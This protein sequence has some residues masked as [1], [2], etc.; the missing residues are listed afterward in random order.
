V[1]PGFEELFKKC[2]VA[3]EDGSYAWTL[4]SETYVSPRGYA[5][6]VYTEDG[7]L[8]AHACADSQ[9]VA[10]FLVPPAKMYVR[11]QLSQEYRDAMAGL[12]IQGFIKMLYQS[13]DYQKLGPKQIDGIDAIGFET[14]DWSNRMPKELEGRIAS[15]LL[16]VGDVTAR[17]W[18]DPE[19]R[20]PI[21]NEVEG[22]IAPCVV[23]LF[24]KSHLR[25]VD[26]AF[27]WGLPIDEAKF[28][29]E[30]PEDYRKITL[31]S[32]AAIGATA[33][34]AALAAI[35]PCW[36]FLARRSRRSLMSAPHYDASGPA[37][38]SAS[39]TIRGTVT[40]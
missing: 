3:Q 11:F 36:I 30:I 8:L 27:T 38:S 7:K 39:T 20:L 4:I 10:T 1:P 32:G 24:E 12:T 14:T 9:G 29:P 28:L 21:R 23:S 22:E 18:I 40:R 6:L 15:F 37:D 33:S 34:G 17:V 2:L 5:N 25:I 16:S 26:D 31:P 19:T 13:G 35:A